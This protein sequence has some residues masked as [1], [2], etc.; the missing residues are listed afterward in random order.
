M[1]A[2]EHLSPYQKA[3]AV[4]R[5]L[6]AVS[7]K[8]RSSYSSYFHI[9]DCYTSLRPEMVWSASP[10]SRFETNVVESSDGNASPIVWIPIW[11]EAGRAAAGELIKE[12]N[13]FA[14][15]VPSEHMGAHFTH[16]SFVGRDYASLCLNC[17]A[18]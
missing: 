14:S 4:L 18:Y 10:D 5:K 2:A 3:K 11:P 6:N 17:V 9:N 13:I 7:P 16:V 15:L 8:H 1:R 12:C